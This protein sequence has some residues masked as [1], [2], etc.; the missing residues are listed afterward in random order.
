MKQLAVSRK[1]RK[2][3]IE[4]IN[5]S[6]QGD[7]AER[8]IALADKLM[9]DGIMP[10]ISSEEQM[11]QSIFRYISS[12]IMTAIERSR[13]ARQRA[14][15]RKQQKADG[16]SEEYRPKKIFV[17]NLGITLVEGK[18]FVK[19]GCKFTI[20]HNAGLTRQQRRQAER[21]LEHIERSRI[22]KG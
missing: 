1:F 8:L 9:T 13:K 2:G 12:D 20:N 7:V 3:I 21:D 6:F 10:D 5:S 15:E 4:K 18:D 22:S 17:A 16:V 19:N 14:A 11:V